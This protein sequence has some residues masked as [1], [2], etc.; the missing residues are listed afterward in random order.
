MKRSSKMML[1]AALFAA[2]G[3]GITS[4][5]GEWKLDAN[6][7]WYEKDDGSY[8]VSDWLN[9]NGK[10]YYFNADGYMLS[11][12]WI[13]NYYVGS[14]G[15][16]LTNT[17]TPDGYYVG[18]DGMWIEGGSPVV[19]ELPVTPYRDM[20]YWDTCMGK[21]SRAMMIDHGSYYEIPNQTFYYTFYDAALKCEV[22]AELYTGSIYVYKDAAYKAMN[23][24]CPSFSSVEECLSFTE[25]HYNENKYS[26]ELGYDNGY[27]YWMFGRN[28]MDE[29]GYFTGFMPHWA[30]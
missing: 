26:G 6:G 15:A 22:S 18:A 20:P 17:T 4:F 16:M 19:S 13:G 25:K 2:L 1:C 30:G 5:A 9:D 21:F 28:H 12:V 24:Y 7:R 23:K 14:D 3:G 10:F 27:F 29:K 8:V 11:N